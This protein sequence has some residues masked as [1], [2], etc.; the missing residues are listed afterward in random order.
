MNAHLQN[1]HGAFLVS[2]IAHRFS[3]GSRWQRR[4]FSLSFISSYLEMKLQKLMFELD[5]RTG[6]NQSSH[7]KIFFFFFFF[8]SFISCL[9]TP[10]L[11]VIPSE[12]TEL[13]AAV[14]LH[15]FAVTLTT[16]PSCCILGRTP[17]SPT[18][19]LLPRSHRL[20]SWTDSADHV[21][22][23]LGAPVGPRQFA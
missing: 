11:Y 20:N 19:E 2:D 21:F 9:T 7:H 14:V 15:G 3:T 12:M 4:D 5:V 23:C 6:D 22:P 18:A 13:P 17:G 10:G 1:L 8:C 16:P